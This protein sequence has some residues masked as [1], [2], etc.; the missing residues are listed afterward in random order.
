MKSAYGLLRE[1]CGLSLKEAATF[2]HVPLDTATAWSSGRRRAPDGVIQEL[3]DL[4]DRIENAAHQ[5]VELIGDDTA[6]V[7]LGIA[8]DDVEAQSLGWPCVG[9]QAASL[10]LVAAYLD[11]AVVIIPRGSTVATAG[12]ADAH[13]KK[14]PRHPEG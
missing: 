9:A 5:A 12:A 4:Y 3:R 11:S 8:S 1:R 6:D 13:D 10:G 14:K 2:H 7:E